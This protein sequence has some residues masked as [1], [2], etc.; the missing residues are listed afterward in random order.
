MQNI[1][2]YASNSSDT[3]YRPEFVRN[4]MVINIIRKYLYVFYNSMYI[5]Q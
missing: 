5:V 2:L 3:F 4:L 1:K